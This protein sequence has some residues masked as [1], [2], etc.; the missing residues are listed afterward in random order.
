MIDVICFCGFAYSFA[1]DHGACPQCGEPVS[2]TRPSHT[3]PRERGDRLD[4][5][6]NASDDDSPPEELAA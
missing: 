3:E 4:H 1:G 2:F 5:V 6:I